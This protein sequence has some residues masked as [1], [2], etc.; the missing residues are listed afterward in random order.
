MPMP[1]WLDSML[2]PLKDPEVVGAK[3]IYRS[4]QKRM[5]ARFMQIEYEDRYKLM[6]GLSSID[7]IDTYSA[8]FRKDRFLEMRG[9]DTSFPVALR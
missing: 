3:G 5:A 4:R 2:D 8:A 7:F 6:A 1:N 9:Y